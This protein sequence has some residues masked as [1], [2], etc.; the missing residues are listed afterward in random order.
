MGEKKKKE[1]QPF[2]FFL[3]DWWYMDQC[4]VMIHKE[5]L[6]SHS[7]MVVSVK[8]QANVLFGD[9]SPTTEQ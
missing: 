4:C 5:A 7:R 6:Q 1:K 2:L 3:V 8:C 9:A